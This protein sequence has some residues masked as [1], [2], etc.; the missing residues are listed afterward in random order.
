MPRGARTVEFFRIWS[1]EMAY[2]LG[3]W[4]ADGYMRHRKDT[5]AHLIEFASI[6]REHLK[7]LAGAVGEAPS[8]RKVSG[9]TNCYEIEF[10]SKE[11]YYDLLA[12][13]G[14]PN[15][16]NVIG[17]PDIPAHLLVHFVRGFVDGDGT[18]VWNGDRPVIQI[19]SGSKRLLE[20]MAVAIEEQT[21]IPAPNVVANRA[22]WYIKWSTTRAKCLAAWL[23]VENPGIALDRKAAIAAKFLEWQPKKRPERGTITEGMRERFAAYLPPQE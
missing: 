22:L 3:Y 18:L 10:C 2:V 1:A 6:D 23:Y 19:Y 8:L 13:G 21:G 12:L 7:K 15:K 9:T 14:M 4:W 16:S 5:G 20:E 11:M 17:F